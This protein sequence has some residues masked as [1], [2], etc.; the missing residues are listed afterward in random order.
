[1]S[2][3]RQ[4]PPEARAIGNRT[5]TWFTPQGRRPTEYELYTVGQHSTPDEWLRVGWPSRFDDG[6]D[7]YV[8]ESTQVRSSRWRDWRDPF[9]VWQ[10]PYVQVANFE[11]QALDRLIPPAL[12]GGGLGAINPAWLTEAIGR[13][14]AVWPFAEYGLFLSLCYA[15]REAL[16]DTVTFALAFEATDKLRHQQDVVRFLLDLAD[17]DPAFSDDQARDAWMSDPVLVPVRENVERIVSLNDWGEILV[18]INLAFEPLVG[19]L[20]KDE[21]LARQASR[22]GDPVTP[23]I[24]AAARRDTDRHLTTT[25]SLVRFLAS[26]PEFGTTNRQVMTHWVRRWSGESAAAAQAAAGLFQIAGITLAGDGAAAL[27]RVSSSHGTLV[28]DLELD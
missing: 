1:L 11:Q 8:A 15:I 9:G 25:S 21:F 14:Y 3:Q 5:F 26:D 22:N 6:R 13:Y 12:A 18:A 24:L 2:T 19:A 27:G 7:P 28:H 16:A 23:M 17:L 4:D 10:R 20:V